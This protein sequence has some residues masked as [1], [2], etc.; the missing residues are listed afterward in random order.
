MILAGGVMVL[1]GGEG[2]NIGCT[3]SVRPGFSKVAR[4]T[5]AVGKVGGGESG[6]TSVSTATGGPGLARSGTVV[7]DPMA[8]SDLEAFGIGTLGST[9]KSALDALALIV[10]GG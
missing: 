8:E 5:V 9:G 2:V 7:V 1:A 3:A 6:S 10:L 4:V